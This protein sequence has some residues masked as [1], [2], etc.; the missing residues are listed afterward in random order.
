MGGAGGGSEAV[1]LEWAVM[2]RGSK[3][4]RKEG[5]GGGGG[6]RGCQGHLTRWVKN[7]KTK[8]PNKCASDGRG[9]RDESG[10]EIRPSSWTWATTPG[11][12]TKTLSS[13]SLSPSSADHRR[14]SHSHFISASTHPPPPPT[15]PFF[16]F[17]PPLDNAPLGPG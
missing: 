7:K 4:Q 16:F 12:K 2:V 10:N 14:T 11:K 17:D 6:Q 8:K 1:G 9:S 15:A 3:G 13:V 5:S